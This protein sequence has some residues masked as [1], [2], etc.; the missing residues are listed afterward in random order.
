MLIRKDIQLNDVDC[1]NVFT[2][3]YDVTYEKRRG[4]NAGYMLD[5]S[6]TDDVIA[7]KAVI[8]LP[9]LPMVENE[10]GDFLS[11][12][13]TEYVKVYYYDPLQKK[14]RTIEA[15]PD[16]VGAAFLFENVDGENMWQT[17]DK[18]VLTER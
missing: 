6:H 8:K 2:A 13:A 16:E 5:G 14:Y 18:V 9:V 4:N 7:I 11:L 10:I 12:L 3:G 1:S 15:E 17:T